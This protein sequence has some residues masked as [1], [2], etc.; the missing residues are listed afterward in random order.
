MLRVY[1]I[2][3]APPPGGAANSYRIVVLDLKQDLDGGSIVFDQENSEPSARWAT[4]NRLII[5]PRGW[6]GLISHSKHNVS[7]IIIEYATDLN[8]MLLNFTSEQK[9]ISDHFEPG[10]TRR[11]NAYSIKAFAR[12][13]SWAKENASASA[14]QR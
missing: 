11:A 5:T 3:S 6:D 9:R 10:V 7:G 14:D 2:R 12:F 8:A 1:I 13:Q 4:N